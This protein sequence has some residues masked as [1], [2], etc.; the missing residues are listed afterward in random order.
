MRASPNG[1]Q[2]KKDRAN[3]RR[4]YCNKLQQLS[5][6]DQ[7]GLSE[8]VHFC[9][10]VGRGNQML[11]ISAIIAV[12]NSGKTLSRVLRHFAENDIDVIVINH[13]STDE[14]SKIIGG[15][16]GKPV[17]KIICEPFDGT[18]SLR[19][20]IELKETLLLNCA[21]DW[22]IHADADE[23]PESPRDGESLRGLIERLDPAG[24]D[25]IDCDEFVF[26]PCDNEDNRVGGDFVASMRRYYHF[27]PKGRTLHRYLRRDSAAGGWSDTGGHGLRLADLHVAPEKVRLRHYIGLSIDHL[28][29][30]YL[31]RVFTGDELQRGWHGNRVP[32]T[33][34][35]V[36][37][38]RPDRLLNL[39]ID[40]WRTDRAEQNHL[41]FHQPHGYSAPAKRMASA[42]YA[43]MPF[44]VGVGR[45]GTTLLRLLLDAHPS[46]AMTPE[47]HWL[48]GAIQILAHSPEKI[49]EARVHIA[50]E[51]CWR[52]MGV[53]DDRLDSIVE[54]HDLLR[55]ADTLRA[56]YRTYADRFGAAFVGDKTPLHNL[57]MLDIANLLPEARFIHLIRDGRDVAVSYRDLWFGPGCDVKAAA[58][59]WMWRIRETRQQAQFLPHYLEV[60]YEELVSRPQQA[61]RRIAEFI[62]VPYD[63][64]QLGAHAGASERL[65]ELQDVVRP[66]GEVIQADRRRS[67][68]ALTSSP[69]DPTR[70]GRWKTLMTPDEIEIFEGIAGDMLSDLGYVRAT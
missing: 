40:G 63:P 38:P 35:F 67:I 27:A 11:S 25:V 61:L 45:S 15:F 46:L 28:R 39:D 58:L 68:H 70:I 44:I 14:T 41:V 49:A 13:G 2:D 3:F 53:S 23:V 43:P 6:V 10:R 57:H 17:S 65:A 48:P 7:I 16:V 22:L 31:G 55:P 33:Q 18:F 59:L 56:I 29:S 36:I 9:S 20:Q 30:Q 69:P 4:K 64:A 32:T 19:R 24:F 5:F 21:S 54:R 12:H 34:D 26:V 47:T 51:P 60:S 66:G 8:P 62:E 52:D 37:A 42:D 1:L 50:N